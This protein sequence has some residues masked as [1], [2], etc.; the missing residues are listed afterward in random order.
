MRACR[1]GTP[2]L[3]RTVGGHGTD[4]GNPGSPGTPRRAQHQP[5]A[6]HDRASLGTGE[7]PTPTP[8][9]APRRGR[10]QASSRASSRRHPGSAG[11]RRCTSGADPSGNATSRTRCQ[12]ACSSVIST[13]TH[14]PVR[15]DAKPAT[16]WRMP[17]WP[18]ATTTPAGPKAPATAGVSRL[19]RAMRSWPGVRTTGTIAPQSRRAGAR[20]SETAKTARRPDRLSKGNTTAGSP[21]S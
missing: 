16:A 21:L 14:A 10:P 2:W 15:S 20:V 7:P 13:R 18:A 6:D 12:S 19:F 4:T 5:A 11:V 17:C 9:R 8:L 1:S 3:R